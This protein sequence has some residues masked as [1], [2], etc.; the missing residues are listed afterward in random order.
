MTGTFSSFVARHETRQCARW[1]FWLLVKIR[2]HREGTR[3]SHSG[4]RVRHLCGTGGTAHLHRLVIQEAMRLF[5]PAQPFRGKRRRRITMLGTIKFKKGQI[6]IPSGRSIAMNDVGRS[7]WI[8]SGSLFTGR[9]K[10]RHRFFLSAFGGGARIAL[11][12][13]AMRNHHILATLIREFRFHRRRDILN[14]N[15]RPACLAQKGLPSSRTFVETA[16]DGR[17]QHVHKAS[18]IDCGRH[19]LV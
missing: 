5:P 13:F 14:R 4:A 19:P 18:V 2:P 3:R 7:E 11:Y 12:E 8:R 10:A 16:T 17:R 1:V 9:V 15:S 6:V